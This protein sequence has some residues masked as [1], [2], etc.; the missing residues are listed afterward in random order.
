MR[1]TVRVLSAE[2]YRLATTR[3]TYVAALFLF[4]VPVLRVWAAELGERAARLEAASRGSALLGLEEGRG[5]AP[6][7]EGWRAGMALGGLLLLI[8]GARSIAGDRESGLLRLATTR[9]ASRGALVLGRAL[10]G[11]VLVLSLVVLSGLGA[12]LASWYWFDFGPLV[13]DGYTILEASEVQAELRLAVLAALPALLA[14]HAFG[15]FISAA[16]RSATGAVAVAVAMLLAF[17]LLKDAVGEARYWVFASFAPSFVDGSAMKEMAG[18]ARGY[19][20]AGYP[21][22]LLRMNFLLPWPELL[23]LVTLT[24]LVLSRRRL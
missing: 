13:E 14:V 2:L 11:P 10:L 20:D 17:D 15:L 3:A 24:G 18:I 12:W 1:G 8:H 16:S 19:S 9:T 7:V 5:W 23:L 22:A 6:L 4:L 21:A